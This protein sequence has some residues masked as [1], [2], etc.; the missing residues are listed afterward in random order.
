MNAKEARKETATNAE[1]I[2][3]R[4]L[5]ECITHDIYVLRKAVEDA[6]KVG[7]YSTRVKIDFAPEEIYNNAGIPSS[8]GDFSN[9][10]EY[11]EGLVT[12]YIQDG[13]T[14][15]RISGR[16]GRRYEFFSDELAIGSCVEMK[17]SW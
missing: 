6:I 15:E 1:R 13:Y 5:S 4:R 3:L 12:S 8:L 14:V 16:T 17:I 9:R 10:A 2:R 11:L 7:K